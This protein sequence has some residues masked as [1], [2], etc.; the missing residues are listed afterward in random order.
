MAWTTMHFA[1]G[2]MGGGAIGL[3][4]ALLAQRGWRWV[5][6]AM[7]AGGCWA[8]LPDLPRF[9]R[10]DLHVP[11]LSSLLREHQ[12]EDRLHAMGDLFFLHAQLDAQPHAYALHGLILVLLLYNGAMA[13]LMAFHWL[14]RRGPGAL[15]GYHRALRERTRRLGRRPRPSATRDRPATPGDAPPR[16]GASPPTGPN[17]RA[18]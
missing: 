2:M 5:P 15:A 11:V 12:V 7:T 6:A 14:E 4:A 3:G 18:A 10:E 17:R 13:W 9:F 8:I 1:I 16:R